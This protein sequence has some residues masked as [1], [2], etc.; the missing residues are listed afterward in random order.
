LL[1]V[2]VPLDI[3]NAQKVEVGD[4]FGDFFETPVAEI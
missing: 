3:N 1:E 4:G 2:L